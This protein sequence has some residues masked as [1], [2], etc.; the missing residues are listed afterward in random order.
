ME[1]LLTGRGAP[2]IDETIEAAEGYFAR[3]GGKPMTSAQR[4]D[5]RRVLQKRDDSVAMEAMKRRAEAAEKEV[6]RLEAKLAAAR[7]ALE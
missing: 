3:Y 5:A 7:R 2:T 4:A 1:W 6:A